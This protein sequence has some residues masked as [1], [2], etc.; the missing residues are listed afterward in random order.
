MEGSSS[1]TLMTIMKPATLDRSQRPMMAHRCLSGL[2]M[3]VLAR[4][5]CLC[6]IVIIIRA[7]DVKWGFWNGK[8]GA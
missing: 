3:L 6:G 7:S 5:R 4:G 8:G 1:P 2:F